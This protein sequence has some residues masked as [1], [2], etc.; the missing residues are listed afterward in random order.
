MKDQLMMLRIVG[1]G[2]QSRNRW[3]SWEDESPINQHSVDPLYPAFTNGLLTPPS[4]RGTIS[5][6]SNPVGSI[7]NIAA[8]LK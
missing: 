2:K 8:G 4:N 1:E 5:T 3:S 6:F 7:H